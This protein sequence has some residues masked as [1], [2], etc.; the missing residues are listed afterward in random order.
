V[1]YLNLNLHAIYDSVTKDFIDLWA[2]KPRV[3]GK[4]KAIVSICTTGGGTAKK[5]EE[6]LTASRAGHQ[7]NKS[8]F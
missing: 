4:K 1:N 2:D 7:M 3:S 5:L 8:A 6:I